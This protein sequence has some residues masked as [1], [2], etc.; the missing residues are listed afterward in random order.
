MKTIRVKI[1]I[2]KNQ[3]PRTPD[4]IPDLT[5]SNIE[6]IKIETIKVVAER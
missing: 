3:E 5:I 2:H 6:E 1:G 4:E